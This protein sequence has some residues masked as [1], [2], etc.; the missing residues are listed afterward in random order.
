[1]DRKRSVK[2]LLSAGLHKLRTRDD[3][4]FA[5]GDRQARVIA[6]AAQKGGV[7]KTTTTVN[8]AAALVAHHGQ[9][10]LV[11]DID[12]QGHVASALRES[13]RPGT[14]TLSDVLLAQRPRDLMEAVVESAIEGLALTPP[15]KRLNDTDAQLTSRVGREHILSAALATAR[16]HF[17]TILIDCPPN[18]GNLTLNAL[19]AA[20]EVLV[21]C[22][23]SILAFEGV[24]DLL[25]TVETVNLRLRHDL[26]VLGILRTR[27][28]VRTRTINET[29]GDALTENYGELML[30]TVIPANSALAKAQACGLSIF[31]FQ[32]RSRGAV[33]YRAL[34]GEVVARRAARGAGAH[35]QTA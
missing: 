35:T 34:A 26:Q 3:D 14:V 9:R 19:M 5:A 33:A 4:T 24:A 6:V 8:L 7:G 15:D 25:G 22:D 10:V 28:D 18:L 21:P 31:Q 1:M 29:I 11:V 20:D 23:L 13:L 30:D 27:V 32:S 17:D 16:T 12:P 2:N